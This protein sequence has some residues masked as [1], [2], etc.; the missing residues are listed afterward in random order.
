M[1]FQNDTAY[2]KQH[3]EEVYSPYTILRCELNLQCQNEKKTNGIV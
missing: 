2:V 3:V 1:N